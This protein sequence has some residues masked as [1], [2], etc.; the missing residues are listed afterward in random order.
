MNAFDYVEDRKSEVR[1]ASD[2]WLCVKNREFVDRADCLKC[3]D[4][5]KTELFKEMAEQRVF[6]SKNRPCLFDCGFDVERKAIS[7]EESV[8]K[9]YW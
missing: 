1:K 9:S 2:K 5:T 4:G 3:K 6:D 7:V 8:D